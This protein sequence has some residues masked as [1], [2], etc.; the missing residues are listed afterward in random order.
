MI[1]LFHVGISNFEKYLEI[2]VFA[3]YLS[4]SIW[5]KIEGS[6]RRIG[7]IFRVCEKLDR[8]SCACE[9]ISCGVGGR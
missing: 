1:R 6:I 9:R 8:V 3:G 2:S 4:V 5:D 7:Q